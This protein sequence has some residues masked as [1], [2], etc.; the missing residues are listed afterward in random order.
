MSE[1]KYKIGETITREELIDIFAREMCRL[2]KS[3]NRWYYVKNNVEQANYVLD[4]ANGLKHLSID[5]G[6]CDEMYEKAYTIYD[7]SKSG[8]T[9]L[10]QEEIAYLIETEV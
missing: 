7:F 10:S 2:Q 4:L 9:G 3:A 1:P 6:I 8:K 5:M